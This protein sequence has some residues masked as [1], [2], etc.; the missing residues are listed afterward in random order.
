ME[1]EEEHAPNGGAA[2]IVAP[3]IAPSRSQTRAPD[4]QEIEERRQQT[5]NI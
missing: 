2:S 4:T 3:L 5:I 1:L